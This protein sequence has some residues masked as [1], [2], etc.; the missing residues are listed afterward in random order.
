MID[1]REAIGYAMLAL[2]CGFLLGYVWGN[3]KGFKY[4]YLS[5]MRSAFGIKRAGVDRAEAWRYDDTCH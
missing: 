2:S 4:G 1:H 3:D 5:G